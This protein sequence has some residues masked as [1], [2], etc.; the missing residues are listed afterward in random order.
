MKKNKLRTGQKLSLFLRDI[1]F[2]RW[3]FLMG[4]VY[5]LVGCSKD[6]PSEDKDC[7]CNRIT[8]VIVN[9]TT[10]RHTLKGNNICTNAP[11]SAVDTDKIYSVGDLKC[12]L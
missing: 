11:Y 9:P 6:E 3:A 1:D 8:E 7:S 4:M 5:F 10:G 2:W 12:N